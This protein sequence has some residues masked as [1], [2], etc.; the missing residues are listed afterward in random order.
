MKADW[1][2]G[3]GQFRLCRNK[4]YGPAVL[5][6]ATSRDRRQSE[7]QAG[8]EATRV[9]PS[10]YVF[11]EGCPVRIMSVANHGNQYAN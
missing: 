6:F 8:T 1:C 2:P 5:R 9:A 10:A 3:S 4:A 11:A 7:I